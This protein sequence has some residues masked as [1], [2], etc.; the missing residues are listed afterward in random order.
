MLTS[1]TLRWSLL[2]LGC[3]AIVLFGA[4]PTNR[5]SPGVSPAQ[6]P[7]QAAGPLAAPADELPPPAVRRSV[8]KLSEAEV[9]EAL[10]IMKQL[11]DNPLAGTLMD[12]PLPG[13]STARVEKQPQTLRET[14][15]EKSMAT[16]A[17]RPVDLLRE[18][19]G[20]VD[21]LANRLEAE[22]LYEGADQLRSTA[23]RLRRQA[24]RIR[25]GKPQPEPVSPVFSRRQS[26]RFPRR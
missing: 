4:T 11:D 22:D 3:S 15:Q 14:S 2:S 5:S 9:V 13:S 1:A 18:I 24:R 10:K 17:G 25:C 6:P 20:R 21:A 23:D 26:R 19:A 8:V 7:P 16:P 12:R